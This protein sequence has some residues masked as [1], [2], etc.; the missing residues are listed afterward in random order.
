MFHRVR[1]ARPALAVA[2]GVLIAGVLAGPALAAPATSVAYP[3][4][5]SATRYSGLAFDTCTAPPLAAMRAWLASPYRAV[6]VYVGGQ[7]RTCSQPELTTSWVRAAANLGW[8]LIPIFKGRQPSC[9]ARPTDLKI[10]P[11]AASAEGTWA[12][13]NAAEQVR[14]LGMFR[15]G[16]IY[17]DMEHYDTADQ[18]CGT[19]VL[20]FLSAW[21]R[22]LHRLGYVA[23]VYENLNLGARALAGVYGST[24]YARPDALWIARYDQNPALTGWSGIGD[25][26]WAVH[27]RAKQYRADFT[28][29]YGG[30]PLRIDA[31]NWNAPVATTAF[32]YRAT[33]L[34]RARTGPSPSYPLVR[35]YPE[36]SS[37]AVVCQTPGA[38]V[39]ATSV[40]D[41]LNNGSYVTDYYLDTPSGTGY[42]PPL[43]RCQYPY[44]VTASGGANERSGPGVAFPVTGVLPAGGLAWMYCQQPGSVVGRTRVWDKIDNRHWVSDNWVATPGQPGYSRPVPR[45]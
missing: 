16:A 34:I 31:D 11:S 45:C 12:A 9:G 17:Y 6:G 13:D 7:N 38:A 2:A 8:R 40:W 18:V 28:A 35:V 3:A 37:V 10:V 27:Q 26:L 20:T 42:S 30:V 41:K 43:T 4:W 23:G 14:A 29:T 39:R 19:A 33:A 15:G 32:S 21:T 22:E 36:G 44:Q 24:R 1:P 5:A 25:S